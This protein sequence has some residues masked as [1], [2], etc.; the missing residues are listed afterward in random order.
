MVRRFIVE[1]ADEDPQSIIRVWTWEQ[2]LTQPINSRN[3]RS[4]MCDAQDEVDAYLLAQ[5]GEFVD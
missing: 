3:W 1:W 4:A 2:W 5:R